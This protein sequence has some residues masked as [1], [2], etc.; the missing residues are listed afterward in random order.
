MKPYHSIETIFVRD[1][2]TKRLNF[3][4]IRL[5]EVTCVNEW[6][7]TEKVDG[8]NIRVIVTLGGIE[9]KGRSENAQ[10]QAG[11]E[12]AVREAIPT[13]ER[14]IEFFT[15]YRGKELPEQ[16]SATFYGECFGKGIQK[17]G[18]L[19]SDT[20]QFRAF[21]L[22]LGEFWWLNDAEL[23]AVTD[24]LGIPTVPVLSIL[25]TGDISTLTTRERLMELAPLSGV[26]KSGDVIPEGIVARPP[27]VLRDKK[28]DRLMWKLTY[29][30]FKG[31]AA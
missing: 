23:R 5:P 3:G 9:V 10:L 17:V 8:T 29:R 13:H 6:V 20:F 2:E 27:Q 14:L 24:Q 7:L 1:P 16:W 21:D 26:A 12:A 19:Y 28:G 15:A 30:E 25:E 31:E 4:E 11:V 22:L 18:K